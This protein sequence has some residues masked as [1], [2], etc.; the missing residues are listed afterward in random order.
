MGICRL[1]LQTEGEKMMSQKVLELLKKYIPGMYS[2]VRNLDLL[3]C[4]I[5]FTNIE[6]LSAFVGTINDTNEKIKAAKEATADKIDLTRLV[7]TNNNC[8]GKV[9]SACRLCLKIIFMPQIFLYENESNVLRHDLILEMCQICMISMDLE[10]SEHPVM[11]WEC[12]ENLQICYSFKKSCLDIDKK[13]TSYRTIFCLTKKDITENIFTEMCNYFSQNLD[14]DLIKLSRIIEKEDELLE[15]CLDVSRYTL[16][17]NVKREYKREDCSNNDK[18]CENKIMPKSNSKRRRHCF[19]EEDDNFLL[20]AYKGVNNTENSLR[21][22][23]WPQIQM[24]WLASFPDKPLTIC[25]IIARINRLLQ[26]TGEIKR[27]RRKKIL[28][29]PPKKPF[30]LQNILLVPAINKAAVEYKESFTEDIP[31]LKMESLS[32]EEVHLT[33]FKLEPLSDCPPSDS[34]SDSES[35]PIPDLERMDVRDSSN[36]WINV[37]RELEEEEEEEEKDDDSECVIVKYYKQFLR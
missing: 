34:D 27:A 15:N 21:K 35:L 16:R 28:P 30:V 11:C 18:V 19:T 33:E 12:W 23:I 31:S 17:N 25:S 20:E 2:I 4:E 3:L 6:T 22:T 26:K 8:H 7:Q 29:R 36:V 37:S 5:C 1:C 14:N 24:K 10:L 9:S 32:N 13:I